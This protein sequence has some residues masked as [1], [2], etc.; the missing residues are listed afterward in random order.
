IPDHQFNEAIDGVFR[1]E[2]YKMRKA[3]A[4]VEKTV[5]KPVEKTVRKPVEKTVR[6]PVEKAVQKLVERK[7]NSN[8]Q[9][10]I[11]VFCA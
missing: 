10:S 7:E 3:Q 4:P 9:Q 1:Q 2:K 8:G 11:D 5:R 6:N